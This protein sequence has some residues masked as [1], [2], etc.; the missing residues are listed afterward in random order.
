MER[1]EAFRLQA[2]H[3]ARSSPLYER[4]SAELADEPLVAALLGDEVERSAPL[5]LFAGLHYLVLLGRG[6]WDDARALVRDEV[7]F[8]R[9]WLAE[10][11][12]QTN[13]V[14]RC[15]WL[16]PCFLEV[17]RRTGA[18]AFDCV[19]LGCSGG[20]NLLWD[21]H[22]YRYERGAWG[23]SNSLL[24]AGEERVSVPGSLLE[25]QPVVRSRVGVDRDPPDL[26]DDEAVRLLQAF[27]WPGEHERLERLDAAV[28]RW[29]KDPPPVV[30][31]DML[32]ELP[33]LLA[34]RR[35]DGLLLV[36]QTAA[37]NYLP[38]ER[39]DRVRELLAAAGEDGPLAFVET[40][41]P[42]DGSHEYYGLFVQIWPGGERVEVAHSDFHGAWLEW[43]A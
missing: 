10:Q 16:L 27:V 9:G 20:L 43:L 6:S 15:W 26:R 21:R 2:R 14:G 38:R 18:E 12:V 31:G 23:A 7:E 4:L 35:D 5:Q 8:L 3:F 17:A 28:A 1:R 34:R 25:R 42:L 11:H 19:E 41:Q 33:S 29:R 30:V 40:W 36:W 37:L 32:D 24:L 13:E 39:R 22:G